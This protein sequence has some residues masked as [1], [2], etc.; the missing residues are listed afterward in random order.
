MTLAAPTDWQPR[1][2]GRVAVLMGGTSAEREVSLASGQAI[3]QA[4]QQLNLDVQPLDL[5][6]N[7]IKQLIDMAPDWAFNIVHGG[8]GEDGLLAAALELL[9]TRS[10]A[11]TSKAMALA[12]HK[13][14][15]KALWR[16]AGLPTPNWC[17]L[18]TGKPASGE[19]TNIQPDLACEHIYAS[20][21]QLPLVIKPP[22]EGSSIG[23][24][25]VHSAAELEQAL[26]KALPVFDQLLVEELISGTEITMG[27]VGETVLPVIEIQPDRGVYDY[28]AKYQ[29]ANTRMLIPTNLG[30][31]I[32]KQAR[33]LALAAFN[34]LGC[35]IWGRVDAMVDAR[36][37]IYLLEINTV[38]GMTDH[39]LVP[40]AAQHIGLSFADLVQEIFITA[41]NR[42]A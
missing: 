6:S 2:F 40:Y 12:M 35:D 36:G 33:E 29:S 15:S 30:D 26:S 8:Y 13:H 22:S 3:L 28:Y 31:A 37:N 19:A 41:Q 4:C 5:G 21:L 39:S 25:L 42:C 18:Q 16:Q 11:S 10:P 38:S 24:Y 9:G 1:S 14:Y 7:P 20:G 27:I 17:L 32:E 23:L 34:A